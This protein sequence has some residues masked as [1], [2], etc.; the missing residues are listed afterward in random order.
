MI[1]RY[2]LTIKMLA[3]II[4]MPAFFIT[5]F[6]L[7]NRTGLH[8]YIFYLIGMLQIL[9]C[10]Y[11]SRSLENEIRMGVRLEKSKLCFDLLT[12]VFVVDFIANIVFMVPFPTRY[13]MEMYYFFLLISVIELIISSLGILFYMPGLN[14]SLVDIGY[15]FISLLAAFEI[16]K[17]LMGHQSRNSLKLIIGC[18]IIRLLLEIYGILMVKRK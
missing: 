11:I 8:N 13:V 6:C 9:L 18:W 4:L 15:V 5:Q 3:Y 14:E 1:K 10:R 17:S 2:S 7:E 12:I 16:T